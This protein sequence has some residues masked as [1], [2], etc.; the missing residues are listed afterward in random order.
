[1]QVLH[2]AAAAVM[3]LGLLTFLSIPAQSSPTSKRRIEDARFVHLGGIEQWITLRGDDVKAPILLLVHGGPGDVQSPFV[4]AYAPYE[5]DFV[6]IQW[7]QRGAGLTYGK[8]GPNTPDLTLQRVSRDGVELVEYL[9]H[10]FRGNPVIVLG[11]SWGSVIATEMVRAR[12]DLFAAYVGTGQVASW[13]EGVNAQFEFLEQKARETGDPAMLSQLEAIG[14]PDPL[15]ANQYFTF[16]QPLRHY[17]DAADTAWL[18][19]LRDRKHYSADLTDADMKSIGEGM[20]FSGRVLLPTQLKE[21]LSTSALTFKLPYFV[22]QGRDDRFTPTV[23]AEAYFAKVSAPQKRL[24]LIDGA[25][26]FALVTHAPQFIQ[27]LGEMVDSI[28]R[29]RPIGNAH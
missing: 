28:P 4:S 12:P 20:E 22:I 7:D 19:G 23:A 27:I 26:H 3:M 24:A 13:A 5:H 6:L 2:R 15:N 17:L 29:H 18:S 9:H 1:M 21:T 25:G 16:T 8:Y 14:H 10:R 11:H